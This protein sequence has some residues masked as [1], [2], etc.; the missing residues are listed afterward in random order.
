VGDVGQ[1][2]DF[3]HHLGHV[4]HAGDIAAAMTNEDANLA[5]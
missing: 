2:A 3:F 1:L 4:H 5:H